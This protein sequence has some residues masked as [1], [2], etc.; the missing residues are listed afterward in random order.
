MALLPLMVLLLLVA[1]VAVA[2]DVSVAV[3][4]NL[5]ILTVRSLFSAIQD[6]VLPFSCRLR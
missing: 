1:A 6:V 5:F 2:N 4:D 3:L